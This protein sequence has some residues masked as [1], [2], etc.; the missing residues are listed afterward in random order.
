MRTVEEFSVERVY[1]GF[2]RL[3]G[4]HASE[5][6]SPAGALRVAQY[7]R[8][9]DFSIRGEHCFQVHFAHVRR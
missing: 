7:P 1:N 5:A 6:D 9:D 8:G 2:T 4:V 3:L